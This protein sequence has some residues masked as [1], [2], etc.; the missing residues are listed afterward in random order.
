MILKKTSFIYKKVYPLLQPC[1]RHSPPEHL[2]TAGDIDVFHER[3]AIIMQKT[4]RKY[5]ASADHIILCHATRLIQIWWR[6]NKKMKTDCR[7]FASSEIQRIWRGYSSRRNRTEIIPIY[8]FAASE[9]QRIWR[10]YNIRVDYMLMVAAAKL[11]QRQFRFNQ[12]RHQVYNK[13]R[14]TETF[15]PALDLTMHGDVVNFSRLSEYE[16]TQR[17]VV[18]PLSAILVEIKSNAKKVTTRAIYEK[19]RPSLSDTSKLSHDRINTPI[20][21]SG[22]INHDTFNATGMGKQVSKAAD[23]S[24]TQMNMPVQ[25]SREAGLSPSSDY[26]PLDSRRQAIA[27][28]VINNLTDNVM[29]K[30]ASMAA[31]DASTQM[32]MPVQ[33]S[34]EAGLSPSSDSMPC[35]IVED[36]NTKKTSC[37][38]T[39]PAITTRK[40]LRFEK[41]VA[42]IVSKRCNISEE[43]LENQTSL[44]SNEDLGDEKNN[45]FEPTGY[46]KVVCVNTDTA[47]EY[48]PQFIISPL[49]SRSNHEKESKCEIRSSEDRESEDVVD[50][51]NQSIGTECDLSFTSSLSETSYIKP[52]ETSVLNAKSL[53]PASHLSSLPVMNRHELIVQS[54]QRGKQKLAMN[55]DTSVSAPKHLTMGSKSYRTPTRE[56]D[57]EH[58]ISYQK[59]T[60]KHEILPRIPTDSHDRKAATLPN[61]TGEN[62]KL[63]SEI[64]EAESIA[65]EII[66]STSA[67]LSFSG[68]RSGSNKHYNTVGCRQI[69][70]LISK[71]NVSESFVSWDKTDSANSSAKV[72]TSSAK[73]VTE[74]QWGNTT[75]PPRII[76]RSM[77]RNNALLDVSLECFAI[78][79][80]LDPST[81]GDESNEVP[82]TEKTRRLK[83]VT[84]ASSSIESTGSGGKSTAASKSYHHTSASIPRVVKEIKRES[85]YNVHKKIDNLTTLSKKV[86]SFSTVNSRILLNN[87]GS[88]PSQTELVNSAIK[89]QR[90]YR[91]HVR[92]KTAELTTFTKPSCD[93]SSHGIENSSHL[94]SVYSEVDMM[95]STEEA[96]DVLQHYSHLSKVQ[97]AV[98]RLETST[99]LCRSSCKSFTETRTPQILYDLIRSCNRSIPHM[100]LLQHVLNIF[101]HVSVHVDLLPRILHK[102]CVE[103]WVDVIQLFRDKDHIFY[104]AALILKRIVSNDEKSKVS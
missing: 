79:D 55:S 11:I 88:N 67:E 78:D 7:N 45:M 68:N 12:E 13:V 27:S 103:V 59:V 41:A 51:V 16:A 9:L 14:A 25:Q 80:A 28:G 30:H 104:S 24:P 33:Q 23:D 83:M 58:N 62:S 98:K 85:Q 73:H 8:D 90:L 32:N 69:T 94:S 40:T 77:S 65:Q 35:T 17:G 26:V 64:K 53:P 71:N 101:L 36:I 19:L 76:T 75:P 93:T 52:K 29:E 10:G 34:R 46:T 92:R 4:W 54:K 57:T 86:A 87:A 31:D 38:V 50:K 91:G 82:S 96:L 74:S 89:I 99:R 6:S 72:Q 66:P 48:T 5:V 47:L 100:E 15:N 21:T 61:Q 44:Y 18:Q 39:R 97:T 56:T 42:A 49:V 20:S 1:I 60:R 22:V 37:A 81:A 43:T 3:C 95:T 63:K 70:R 84:S 102:D 2:A